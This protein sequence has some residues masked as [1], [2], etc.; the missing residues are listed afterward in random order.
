MTPVLRFAP[1]PT[2][3]LHVGNIRIALMNWLYT[4]K[5]NGKFI[6]RMD[7]T[8]VERS[9]QEFAYGILQDLEWLGLTHDEL[10]HQ[11]DRMDNYHAVAQ[12]LIKSGR[13]YACY[14][15]PEELEIKRKQLLARGKPP[16]YDRA[17]LRLT[18]AEKKK[19]E[20]HGHKPHWR[21]K[22]E[23][24][25]IEWVDLVHGH[26]EFGADK[27]SDPV[28]I[29][30]DG[31]PLYTLSS[32]VDD[33]ELGVTHIFRGDDHI[34]NTAVQIQL[35]EAITGKASAMTFCHL[36]LVSDAK[37]GGL[38]KRIGSLSIENLR[39]EGIEP[40]AIL[41][42]L[43]TLGTSQSL[44][45]TYDIQTLIDS[46]ATAH[47][48]KSTFKFSYEDLIAVN[49]KLLHHMPFD[50]AQKRLKKMNLDIN[51]A[52]WDHLKGNLSMFKD[53]EK[54]WTICHGNV[55]PIIR[56]PEFI[57]EALLL[58]P[59]GTWDENTWGAWTE[60]V[61]AKTEVMGKK[62]FMPLREA[63]TGESHGPEMKH[64]LPLI[65]EAKVRTRLEGHIG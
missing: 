55:R 29:R 11:S 63:I 18:E 8:D 30:E 40:M 39:E 59:T 54:L 15:P 35:I 22:L 60:Q 64:L 14:E 12:Q 52:T 24:Q 48:N 65:G 13:L 34:A 28:L 9:T 4:R 27:L 49:Q 58:L 51:E 50:E 44:K 53:I 37:G 1:S 10:Y 17:G 26:V 56:D 6:L 7:D 5:N 19:F 36:P 46:F 43:A 16:I 21:F 25:K 45:L 33:I 41:C 42:L 3:R 47:I 38:S 32:V 57:R 20:E 2:G 61:K 31:M 23:S 62:L